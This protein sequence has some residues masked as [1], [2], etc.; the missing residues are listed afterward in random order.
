MSNLLNKIHLLRGLISGHVA[1]TGPFFVDIDLTSRCNLH[2]VSC[3]YHSPHRNGNARPQS[4]GK[5]LSPVL[6]QRLCKELKGLGTHTLVLQGSGEPTLHADL[7]EM[8]AVARRMGFQVELITNGTLIDK[9]KAEAL[10]DSGLNRLKVSLWAS[11]K[12]QYEWVYPGTDPAFFDRVL[13]GIRI[14]NTLRREKN[15]SLPVTMIYQPIGRHNFEAL[16]EV[17]DLVLETQ[18]NGLL[19]S[20]LGTALGEVGQLALNKNEE[21]IVRKSLA[22]AKLRLESLG[23]EHNINQILSR[24]SLGPEVWKTLPCY[25]SWFHAR[26]RVDG[27]VE[28]CGRCD[29]TV[30]FGNINE[31]SFSSIWNGSAIRG[32]RNK[33]MTLRG[34]AAIGKQCDC[35]FCCYVIDNLRIHRTY[36]WIAPLIRRTIR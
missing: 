32:F 8:I 1:K 35:R 23:L 29:S 19:L 14:M 7:P 13:S 17:I 20:P 22:K 6:F 28:P 34:L 30:R 33:S 4:R 10:I 5:D 24:Y 9:K 18:S 12:T 31:H 25:I 16:D 11:S 3:I 26:I 21:G 36:R 15:T 2:C 27:T